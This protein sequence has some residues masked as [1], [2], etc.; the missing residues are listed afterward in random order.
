VLHTGPRDRV[1]QLAPAIAGVTG[2]LGDLRQLGGLG[3]AEVIVVDVGEVADH[4]LL[5]HFPVVTSPTLINRINGLEHP[6]LVGFAHVLAG[7]GLSDAT[8]WTVGDG[9]VVI[10]PRPPRR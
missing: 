9:T 2:R 7:G 5:N 3:D 6:D 8:V 10:L 1:F 4:A